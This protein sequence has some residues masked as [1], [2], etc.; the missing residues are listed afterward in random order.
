MYPDDFSTG[1]V[2]AAQMKYE[3]VLPKISLSPQLVWKHDV[4]GT[5]PSP[6]ANFVEDRRI[7]DALLEIRY[8]DR[9]ALYVGYQWFT[10]GG[11]AN[12]LRDRDSARAYI[13]YAF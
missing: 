3:S 11:A 12:L 13:K 6:A 1:Y 5:A 9:L 10:G 7:A 8:K 4:R 2:I